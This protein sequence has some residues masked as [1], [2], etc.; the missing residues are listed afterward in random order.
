M[1]NDGFI[2]DLLADTPHWLST[3][4]VLGSAYSVPLP[5]QAYDCRP[6]EALD[7]AKS[8]WKRHMRGPACRR[9]TGSPAGAVVDPA[10][11]P[12][13]TAPPSQASAGEALHGIA[14]FDHDLHR[15]RRRLRVRE[16][17]GRHD[18]PPEDPQPRKVRSLRV[19]RAEYRQ[20]VGAVRPAV[21]HRRARVPDFRRGSRALLPL[22]RRLRQRGGTGRE[23]RH[24][25]VRNPRRRDRRHALFF[26]RAARR[27]R[28][29]VAVRLPRLGP[30]GRQHEPQNRLSTRHRPPPR[31]PRRPGALT[32]CQPRLAA[33]SATSS[34]APA[35]P[36][37]TS[38][39]I[40][41][42]ADRT[43]GRPAQSASLTG[44]PSGVDLPAPPAVAP[45]ATSSFRQ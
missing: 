18:G 11:S 37:R 6:C 26:R 16:P 22:G 43:A 1:G 25:D 36:A 5:L 35:C 3:K 13:Y 29:P 21:L 12:R 20:L 34:A 19:R 4:T 41:R 24:D 38:P 28:L 31:G 14:A 27:L 30:L 45:G 23:D 40:R 10:G 8:R 9:K 33:P 2:T 15:L 7:S 42:K 44:R 39:T 32:R 17:R